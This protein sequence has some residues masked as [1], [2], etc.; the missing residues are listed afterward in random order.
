MPGDLKMD[1][2]GLDDDV[3]DCCTLCFVLVYVAVAVTVAVALAGT[4]A[5][6]GSCCFFSRGGAASKMLAAEAAAVPGAVTR[7]N[8]VL[9]GI[10]AAGTAGDAASATAGC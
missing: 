3:D 2:A 1:P 6:A 10:P 8:G 9:T 4:N 7:A 5:D